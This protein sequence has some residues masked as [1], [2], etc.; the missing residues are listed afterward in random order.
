MPYIIN[1]PSR[2]TTTSLAVQVREVSNCEDIKI[3]TGSNY[4][5]FVHDG[6]E[7]SKIVFF[8]DLPPNGINIVRGEV[9]INGKWI[10][11]EE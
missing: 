5:S 8:N 2:S 10:E 11:L 3:S 7:N 4:Q 6:S 9:K 1:I